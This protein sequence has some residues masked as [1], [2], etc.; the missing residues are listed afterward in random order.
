MNTTPNFLIV[1]NGRTAKHFSRYLNL[2]G[3]SH[4]SWNRSDSVHHLQNKA[5]LSSHIIILINDNQID[6]FI[7][8]HQFEHIGKT[9]VHFSGA[10]NSKY[11]HSAHP[12]MTFDHSMYDLQTYQKI[13]F[14]CTSDSLSFANLLPSIP[15]K[16]IFIPKESKSHYHAMCVM[17]NNFTTL[18]WQTF[19]GEMQNKFSIDAVDAHPFLNQTL[20]NIQN[21][22]QHALTG[23]IARGDT[24]TIQKHLSE[25]GDMP[26]LQ[27]LY[28]SFIELHKHNE[29]TR[30]ENH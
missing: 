3:H 11:A 15:N 1:G 12:L 21:D 30:H 18:L 5:L 26:Y 8:K 16:H 28:R 7:E 20:K 22:H 25:L 27:Q 14:V 29:R 23:P 9:L 4:L 6:P 17:A 10:L 2:L 24:E 19:F 13:L